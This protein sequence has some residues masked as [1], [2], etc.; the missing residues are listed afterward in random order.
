[1]KQK[2]VTDNR[3][4]RQLTE[5]NPQTISMLELIDKDFQNYV[6][7]NRGETDGC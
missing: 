6:K 2:K 4:M 7:E 3:E 1:M 5:A